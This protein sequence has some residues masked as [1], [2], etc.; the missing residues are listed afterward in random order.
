VKHLDSAKLQPKSEKCLLVGYPKET[1]GYYFYHPSDNKMFVAL[2]AVFLEKEFV[3]A[4]LSGR[5][6]DLDESRPETVPG[7]S[8]LL[9]P[10]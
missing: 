8:T 1:K 3:S 10:I 4:M 5:K 7:T 9:E 2:H 6:V